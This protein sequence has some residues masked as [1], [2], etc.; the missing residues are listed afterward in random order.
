[1]ISLLVFILKLQRQIYTELLRMTIV[2]ETIQDLVHTLQGKTETALC[3]MDNNDMIAN[4]EK[5]KAI[6]LSKRKQNLQS[7][8]FKTKLYLPLKMLT[9]WV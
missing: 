3:W 2:V 9:C 7:L 8:F 6:V 4:A 1:M 5:F